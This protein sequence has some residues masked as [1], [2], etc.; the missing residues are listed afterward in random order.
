MNPSLFQLLAEEHRS[1]L[2]A[3]QSTQVRRSRRTPAGHRFAS[4]ARV[5]VGGLL[6][7]IGTR[8][9]GP[10]TGPVG[11]HRPPA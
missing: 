3:S 8:L 1:E 6:V 10:R 2:V 5:G 7:T 9:A 11:L 4:R